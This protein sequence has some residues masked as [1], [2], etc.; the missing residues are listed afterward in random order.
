MFRE[1]TNGKGEQ[2][3]KGLEPSLFAL[4][5][6]GRESDLETSVLKLPTKIH[7]WKP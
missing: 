1:L 3:E 7:R 2:I 6:R 5:E 4:I